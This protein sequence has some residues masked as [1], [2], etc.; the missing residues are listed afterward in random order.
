ML[1]MSNDRYRQVIFNAQLYANMGAGTYEKAVDMATKDFLRAG[2]N[3]VEYKNGSRHTVEDYTDMAIR[4]AGKRA[5]LTGEGEKRK[6]WGISTVIMNKRGNPCAKCLPF[7]GKVLIDDVWSGGKQEDG[8]YQLMSEAIAQGLYHP[9]CKDS[10]TTYFPELDNGDDT[11]TKEEK[12]EVIDNYN[13]EQK[14]NYCKTEANKLDRM[15]KYSLDPDNKRMYQA[16]ADEWTDRYNTMAAKSDQIQWPVK[17]QKI[18]SSEYKGI[19]SYARA[20]NIELSG[21]KQFDGQLQTVVDLIDDAE[22]VTKKYPGITSGKKRLTIMLEEMMRP[23]DFAIT[24]GHIIS[25]NA[26]AY[27]NVDM[28]AKEYSK[29]V[30]EG[31][32][33]KGTDYHSIIKHEIGHVISNTYG[34]DGLEIAMKITGINRKD[35]MEFVKECLSEYAGE[36]KDGS[37]IISEVFS[38]VYNLKNPRE[39][40]LQFIDECARIKEKGM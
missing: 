14:A 19:M 4:T 11:P 15:A 34:I 20:H 2:I 21:F 36:F 24:R 25:I 17:G 35:T 32:F 30:D 5:Y 27:R 9:R 3:C 10:H 13:Q 39:F 31:W 29:L 12:K 33:V 6:E 1:R 26:N 22:Q 28:L 37:E 38:E 7:V 40:S 18:S 16:R 8:P 23:E